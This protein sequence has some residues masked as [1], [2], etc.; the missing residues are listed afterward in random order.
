MQDLEGS[1]TST[2][3]QTLSGPIDPA[4]RISPKGAERT[5]EIADETGT[6]TPTESK[7]EEAQDSAKCPGDLHPVTDLELGIIGW[8]GQDDPAHPLNFAN[9]RKWGLLALMSSM[10]LIS[11]LASSMF[12]PAVSDA[13]VDLHVT[14]ETLLS[15]SVTI[16]LLGYTVCG[17]LKSLIRDRLWIAD[18]LST[19]PVRPFISSAFK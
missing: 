5:T 12:A 8:E 7:H 6:T 2:D 17:Y 9:S 13:A 14:N 15:F 16:Y 11:P 1:C 3:E 18:V 4:L 10:T 19:Q